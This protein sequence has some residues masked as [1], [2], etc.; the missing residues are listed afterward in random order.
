MFRSHRLRA[1]VFLLIYCLL[2][3]MQTAYSTARPLSQADFL[4]IFLPTTPD[5]VPSDITPDIQ[6]HLDEV[7]AGGFESPI[8]VTHA[9]DGSQ[10]LFVVEQAGV[11]RIIQNNN[12]L[13][14]PFLDIETLVASGGERGLLGLAFHP[15]Y[16]S[17]G[18]F[19]VNYT[20]R[21][22]I[23]SEVGDTVIARYTVSQ[24]NPNQADP[25]SAQILLVIDQ[26]HPN[27]N[28][29]HLVFGPDHYLYIGMGDGGSGG[30]PQNYAQNVN[31]LLGKLLRLDVDGASPYGLPQDNPFVGVPGADEIWAFGLRNPWRFSFDRQN[32]D[33]YIGD[34]GQNAWEEVSF[35]SGGT[36]GGTNFGWRC[37]EGSHT[38][39][40]QPPCHDPSFLA[41]LVDPIAEYDRDD[42]RSVTGGFVYR[43]LNYPNLRGRYFFGDFVTGRLWSLYRLPGDSWSQAELELETGFNISSFGEDEDGE[44]LVVNYSSGTIHRLNEVTPP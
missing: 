29:G 18:F 11:I 16:V 27:H 2:F 12:V 21:S 38:Y 31:S 28:G 13:A 37:R 40:T 24:Q 20:R 3:A 32:G 4:H 34:V 15:E 8:L 23:P 19:Y 43:G 33:L 9:G 17:N 1:G 41:T 36:P 39:N 25:Q 5:N 26:P 6:I 22:P 42:G 10:R 44:L 14:D 30:D 7:I 35:Q